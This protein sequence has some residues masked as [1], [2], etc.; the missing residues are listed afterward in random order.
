MLLLQLCKNI[1]SP[2]MQTDQPLGSWHV[3]CIVFSP[4]VGKFGAFRIFWEK[5]LLIGSVQ[6]QSKCS[7]YSFQRVFGGLASQPGACKEKLQVTLWS[8]VESEIV[9]VSSGLLSVFNSCQHSWK[10]VFHSLFTCSIRFVPSMAM[11][12]HSLPWR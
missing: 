7:I 5:R 10:A 2:L 3:G 6:L 12:D 9:G 8:N 1:Q 4:V 11:L